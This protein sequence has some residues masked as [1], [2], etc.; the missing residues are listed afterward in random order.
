MYLINLF[1]IKIFYTIIDSI[2]CTIP[3]ISMTYCVT[4]GLYLPHPSPIFAHL[5]PLP[6]LSHQCVL[7]MGL[8]QLSVCCFVYF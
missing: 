8:I 7:L 4:G 6:S 3:F 2:T 1:F 5:P